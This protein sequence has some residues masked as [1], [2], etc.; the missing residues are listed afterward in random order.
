M[1]TSIAAQITEL[2]ASHETVTSGQVA[3]AAGVSRQ[4]A[5]YTLKQLERSGDIVH[6]GAGRGGRYRRRAQRQTEYLLHDLDENEVW[7]QEYAALKQMDLVVFDNPNV[8]PILNFAFTEMVNNAIDHSEGVTLTVRWFFGPDMI[9]FEVEDDGIGAF[10]RMRDSRDLESDFD[11]IGEIAKGKQST[12][13]ARHSGL[14]IFFT[15]RMS[16]EFILMSSR[17]MWTVDNRRGDEA[18]GWLDD[19]RI[20]TRVRCEVDATTTISPQKV[21]D[22][23]SDPDV[24][25]SNK[26][27]IRVS[28]FQEGGF[29]SRAEAKKLGAHL[30]T[31]GSVDLDFEGIESV[32][33]GFVDELFRVWQDNHPQTRL[34][35]IRANPSILS[36]IAMTAPEAV[37]KNI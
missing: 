35:P 34:I 14:G 2:F 23:L 15:S 29:V 25:G 9:A 8:R 22:T 3:Q 10:R 24:I 17:L 36:L 11:A 30:E 4:A 26:T 18:I 37:P 32:G 7:G 5:H 20:G 6:E 19:E 21:F 12:A 31:F 28:L 33:Q 13:P 16:S 27:T 1:S